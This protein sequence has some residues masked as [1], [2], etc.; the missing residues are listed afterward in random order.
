MFRQ[1]H[2]SLFCWISTRSALPMNGEWSAITRFLVLIPFTTSLMTRSHGGFD[3]VVDILASSCR[4]LL[5]CSVNSLI[6]SPLDGGHCTLHS[7]YL[8]LSDCAFSDTVTGTLN[9]LSLICKDFA[10]RVIGPTRAIV[11]PW[12]TLL[13]VGPN[14]VGL[15]HH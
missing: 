1:S 12:T 8:F 3:L 2:V 7:I 4:L 6:I 15:P 11:S 10:F 14:C 13:A 5:T 9:L